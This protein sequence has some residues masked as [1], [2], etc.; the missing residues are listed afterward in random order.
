MAKYLFQKKK[1]LPTEVWSLE[2]WS[3]LDQQTRS[4]ALAAGSEQAAWRVIVS[5]A[6]RVMRTYTT[7]FFIVTRFLP[8]LKR[9]EVEVIYAAV[10]YPDEI[11]DSF[12]LTSAE[13]LTLLDDWQNDYEVALRTL[14]L[15][16]SLTRGLPCFLSAFARVVRD[17]HIP[18]EHYR[19]FLDAMR[20]DTT[21]RPF[22]SLDDLIDNYIY[23]SAIVVGFFLTHVYGARTESDFNRALD[24]ARNLGIALQLTNFL[25]DIAEDER[26]GRLY[27]PLDLLRAEGIEILDTRDKEQA[28]ALHAVQ[29]RLAHIA[30][31]YYANARQNLDAFNADCRP[32]I[33]ACIEV[34]GRLNERIATSD[35]EISCRESVP[36]R[37]KFR[38]LPPSKY[39]RIPL[40]YFLR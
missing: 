16:D 20:R 40:A 7:S 21:P 11:V 3:R 10:R 30:R 32:A 25:R 34:Y 29:R 1:R 15:D 4:R 23:G 36:L 39:W 31:D 2:E 9:A 6:R 38:V 26:R 8:A 27:L 12:P 22:S 13:R 18:A 24:S 37:E 14:S 17:R 35:R 19:A 28:V 33:H 5:Q